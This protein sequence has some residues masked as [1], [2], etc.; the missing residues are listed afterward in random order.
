[1]FRASSAHFQEDIVVYMQ[2]MVSKFASEETIQCVN[3][4]IVSS[5]TN[6]ETWWWPSERAETCSLGNKY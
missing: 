6:F 5:E 3:C 4:C 2:H 1:M